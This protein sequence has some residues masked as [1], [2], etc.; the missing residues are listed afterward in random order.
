[1]KAVISVAFLSMLSSFVRGNDLVAIL[2]RIDWF[3]F[4]LSF[5]LVPIMLSVSCLKWKMLLSVRNP[6]VSFLALIR[7]YL[8]GYFFSNLLPSNI[9]GDVVRSFYTGQLINS[10]SYAAVSIFVERFS[11]IL[12]L[13][14]LV[15]FAP[16][17]VPYLYKSPY[18]YFPAGAACVLLFIIGWVWTVKDPLRLPDTIMNRV[19]F[20]LKRITER[21]GVRVLRK[22]VSYCEQLYLAF[23]RKLTKFHQELT[24]A[25]AI[26]RKDRILLVKIVAITVFFY[27][28]TWLNIYVSFLAFGVHLSFFSICALVPVIMFVGH[29][30]VTLLGN[31]GYFESVFVF[32][33]L[34]IN[35]APAESLAMGLLL[36]L[37]M[38]CMGAVGYLVYLVYKYHRTKELEQLE[39]FAGSN[40]SEDGAAG[41]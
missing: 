35:I 10:Q 6:D 5:L 4:T 13:I 7:I 36:R 20:C 29:L 26:I 28:L 25:V 40:R 27:F 9:G 34:L 37:K 22:I 17:L 16:L 3:Y 12:F 32:Y 38:M 31:L 24:S 2:D 33:F 8:I 19:F 14:L 11:G 39:E 23:F 41:L 1:M 15:I 18:V 21:S 30:P